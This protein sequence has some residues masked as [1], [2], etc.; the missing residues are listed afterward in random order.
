MLG[1]HYTGLPNQQAHRHLGTNV[2]WQLEFYLLRDP[3]AQLGTEVTSSLSTG[4]PVL[5][6]VSIKPTPSLSSATVNLALLRASV[7]VYF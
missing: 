7:T 6:A 5:E 1:A 4:Y 2:E 3:P